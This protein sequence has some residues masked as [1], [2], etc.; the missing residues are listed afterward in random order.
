MPSLL[1]F[2][3]PRC[4]V[5]AQFSSIYL[6]NLS[7]LSVCTHKWHKANSTI[8]RILTA[9]YTL[10]CTRDPLINRSLLCRNPRILQGDFKLYKYNI[11]VVEK[12]ALSVKCSFHFTTFTH[13]SEQKA[14]S[15]SSCTS[16]VFLTKLN[17]PYTLTFINNPT[18]IN[19]DP[20]T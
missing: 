8:R 6:F 14:S 20:N 7:N 19:F 10:K 13:A 16:I 2:F 12:I 15:L 3:K 9:L 4:L 5:L 18:N 11:D 1:L 17:Y